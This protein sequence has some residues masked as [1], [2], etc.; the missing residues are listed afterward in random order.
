MRDGWGGRLRRRGCKMGAVIATRVCKACRWRARCARGQG[1]IGTRRVVGGWLVDV[2]RKREDPISVSDVKEVG[3]FPV[4]KERARR[5]LENMGYLGG[6]RAHRAPENSLQIDVSAPVGRKIFFAA[7][8]GRR[9]RRRLRRSAP[10]VRAHS[11]SQSL[12]NYKSAARRVS[13]GLS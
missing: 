4:S 13:V 12:C 7:P 10:T 11:V 5:A 6:L 9:L 8:Y 1:Y 2:P 3:K